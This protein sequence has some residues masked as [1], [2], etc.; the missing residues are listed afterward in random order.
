MSK[1][2]MY[3]GLTLIGLVVVATLVFANGES[4][5]GR[6]GGKATPGSE[7]GTGST[8]TTTPTAS[9]SLVQVSPGNGSA[10]GK[11]QE[12][13]FA[14]YD[15][16]ASDDKSS[17]VDAYDQSWVTIGTWKLSFS[18][19]ADMC[20][21]HYNFSTVNAATG[22]VE[23]LSEYFQELRLTMKD[24]SGKAYT[25]GVNPGEWYYRPDNGSYGYDDMSH[26]YSLNFPSTDL[27]TLT[28]A[29][30]PNGAGMINQLVYMDELCVVGTTEGGLT[31]SSDDTSKASYFDLKLDATKIG[32]PGGY[33]MFMH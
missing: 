4:L 33:S 5:Q 22:D 10:D 12:Y 15:L 17:L 28:L 1:K 30:R 32:V 11:T 16:E 19:N 3:L 6:F 26:F 14:S 21:G 20:P 2:P 8:E 9:S 23:D 18:S 27:V 7:L 31:W 24:S 29:G 25:K 13:L